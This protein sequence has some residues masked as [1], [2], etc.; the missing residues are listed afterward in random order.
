[1]RVAVIGIGV[2]GKV[3]IK[4]IRETEDEL[5]AVCDTD[6]EKLA[7]YPDVKGYTDYV[8][9]LDEIKPDIVHICTPHYLHTEMILDSLKRD[10][11]TLCEKPICIKEEDIPIILEAEKR[12]KAQLGVCFQNRY[13]PATLFVKEYLQDQQ[14]SSAHGELR[15]H[16][17]KKY[18]AQDKWRGSKATEGGGVLINQ[19]LHTIDLLQYFCGMPKSVTAVC[20]NRTLQ[21]VID[22]EDTANVTM[23]GKNEATMYATNAAD[24][25][26]PVEITFKTNEAE[27]RMQS[28][29]VW[30]NG[31]AYDCKQEGERYGKKVYGV[32]HR[33][34]INDFYDC[35]KTGRKF[36]IDGSEAVKAVNIV[37]AAYSSK[38]LEVVP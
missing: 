14:L 12:S 26:Y 7:L 22:V 16:R 33:G 17:D 27:I 11:H 18:Y 28:D 21:G 36:L 24:K 20:E 15:W 30:I 38:G 6:E 5:V 23:Y 3:H 32:G 25:D 9:M 35:V 1:M 34:L 37:L 10:I 19:A 13:N 2:I 29:Y 8:T 4:V 31:E